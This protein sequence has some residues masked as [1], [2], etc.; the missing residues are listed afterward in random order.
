MY[1][2]IVMLEFTSSADPTFFQTVTDYAKRVRN[3]CAGLRMYHFGT[4]EAAR[5]QGYTHAVVSAFKDPAAHDAYQVSPVHVEMK[6]YMSR[7]IQ[8]LVV[9]DGSAPLQPM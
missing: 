6:A 5:A 4:N 7:Y 2:H 8:R 3:E 9:F 1:L